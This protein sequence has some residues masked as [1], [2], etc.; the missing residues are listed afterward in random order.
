MNLQELKSADETPNFKLKVISKD[1]I[2]AALSRAEHYRLL[3]QPN[4]AES[5]CLDILEQDPDNQK[6]KIVLLLSYTDQFN[7]KLSKAKLAN[8]LANGLKD[9]YSKLYYLGI[10]RERQGKAAIDSA[11]PG[12]DF[13][14]YEWYLEAMEFYEKADE[15]N[16]E[17]NEDVVLRWNTCARII[18]EY[19]LKSRPKDMYPNLE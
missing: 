8:E 3:N 16:P 18:M 14:A 2:A 13:D 4:L 7:Q 12:S 15:I 19:R 9:D 11:N 10:I 6:T 17:G 5:I 1:G